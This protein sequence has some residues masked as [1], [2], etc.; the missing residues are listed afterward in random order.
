MIYR[1][2]L[3]WITPFSPMSADLRA[4]LESGTKLQT[5]TL[6]LFLIYL[7]HKFN[8]EVFS[9]VN[10]SL[11]RRLACPMR[12]EAVARHRSASTGTRRGFGFNAGTRVGAKTSST[13]RTKWVKKIQFNSGGG[14]LVQRVIFDIFSISFSPLVFPLIFF[15][16]S[17][18][19]RSPKDID[20]ITDKS[21]W[22]RIRNVTRKISPTCAK[23]N[24]N[25]TT[26]GFVKVRN[27]EYTL[28]CRTVST[29]IL[30]LISFSLSQ[31]LHRR[32]THSISTVSVNIHCFTKDKKCLQYRSI[33]NCYSNCH[34]Y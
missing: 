30:N 22:F 17:F 34:N 26:P 32:K 5:W 11:N 16:P 14:S 6:N 27:T 13:P 15:L 28:R 2:S 9:R 33:L 3:P 18:L 21:R 12:S 24:V 25:S 19:S 23:E 29:F 8:R 20:S 1:R 7:I 4:T 31:A 10:K